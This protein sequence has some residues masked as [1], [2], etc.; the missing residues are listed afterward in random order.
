[1]P[2][3]QNELEKK[4][5][6][7]RALLLEDAAR[8]RELERKAALAARQKEEDSRK[9]EA[10]LRLQLWQA[11]IKALEETKR[12]E[13]E[14][15]KRK[16]EEAEVARQVAEE[17][18]EREKVEERKARTAA[19][20]KSHEER[21]FLFSHILEVLPDLRI[22]EAVALGSAL[23]KAKWEESQI[24]KF[25]ELIRDKKLFSSS[26]IQD[27][28]QQI[29]QKKTVAQIFPF[30][31]MEEIL[32]GILELMDAD[33]IYE[34]TKNMSQ[35]IINLGIPDPEVRLKFQDVYINAATIYL[36]LARRIKRR[37]MIDEAFQVYYKFI[38]SLGEPDVF[39][40]DPASLY[41]TERWDTLLQIQ[42]GRLA[43]LLKT[44]QTDLKKATG[45]FYVLLALEY[46]KTQIESGKLT[47]EVSQ[48]L[49]EE[50]R[51]MDSVRKYTTDY[52]DI[53]LVYDIAGSAYGFLHL[54][55]PI[56][57]ERE[58]KKSQSIK[59][60]E[61]LV[62]SLEDYINL[63]DQGR[64]SKDH[65][66]NQELFN[67]IIQKIEDHLPKF[68]AEF[69]KLKV[70]LTQDERNLFRFVEG[71]QGLKLLPK[72]LAL[73]ISFL[74]E[75]KNQA[76]QI[77]FDKSAK[78]KV[79]GEGGK[80]PALQ[81]YYD[82]LGLNWF[83]Q[84]FS[85]S[86]IESGLWVGGMTVL[87]QMILE[88][89]FGIPLEI[90]P[91]LFLI[92]GFFQFTWHRLHGRT[93]AF[94]T[95]KLLITALTALFLIP[96]SL[97]HLT[98]SSL[99]VTLPFLL[100]LPHLIVN[101][102]YWH[103][104]VH[105]LPKALLN[106]SFFQ[107]GLWDDFYYGFQIKLLMLKADGGVL[108]GG[109]IEFQQYINSLVDQYKSSQKI[110][111]IQ[112]FDRLERQVLKDL[113]HTQDLNI[114]DPHEIPSL[115]GETVAV[116]VN[117]LYYSRAFNP[118]PLGAQQFSKL[119]LKLFLKQGV[120]V[121]DIPQLLLG[122]DD[123]ETV[124]LNPDASRSR[125]I[126]WLS[127]TMVLE[128][129]KALEEALAMDNKKLETPLIPM[130]NLSAK[131]GE[132]KL[133]FHKAEFLQPRKAF[134][135]RAQA[136]AFVLF[137]MFKE[138][139]DKIRKLVTA[140]T[141]NHGL[142][143]AYAVHLLKLLYPNETKNLFAEIYTS[144]SIK[145]VKMDAIQSQPYTRVVTQDDQGKEFSG[146]DQANAFVKLLEEKDKS[147]GQERTLLHI[148]NG[149]EF[150]VAGYATTGLEIF[151]QLER[152][153]LIHKNIAVTVPM[154]SSGHAAGIAWVLKTLALMRGA[155]IKVIGIQ[156]EKVNAAHQ[157]LRAGKVIEVPVESEHHLDEDQIAVT[158][159]EEFAVQVLLKTLDASVI[160][161][162]EDLIR[163]TM[164]VYDDFSNS[165]QAELRGSRVEVAAGMNALAIES[166][167][168][169]FNDR[170]VII[171]IATGG[172]VS[173][174]LWQKIEA[175]APPSIGKIFSKIAVKMK[176]TLSVLL[177]M[178]LI[179]AIFSN[180]ILFQSFSHSQAQT[181]KEQ[182]LQKHQ[183]LK[184][185]IGSSL[186]VKVTIKPSLTPLSFEK[187]DGEE[188]TFSMNPSIAVAF[189]KE[190]SPILT[191]A[192]EK[193]VKINQALLGQ[194]DSALQAISN[195]WSSPFTANQEASQLLY[196]SVRNIVAP[197]QSDQKN[198]TENQ[199]KLLSNILGDRVY[200]QNNNIQEE[201]QR[202]V[203]NAGDCSSSIEEV[204]SF[205]EEMKEESMGEEENKGS[206]KYEVV[207]V[208][209]NLL[210]TRGEIEKIL[211][212]QGISLYEIKEQFRILTQPR[213]KGKF[214]LK[215]LIRSHGLADGYSLRVLNK[216]GL[217]SLEGL[218]GKIWQEAFKENRIVFIENSLFG[219]KVVGYSQ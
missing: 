207:I 174:E 180:S 125:E 169:L 208:T 56:V 69:N 181:Y 27:L 157:S 131:A 75:D 6:E 175:R 25:L 110:D 163:A 15:K 129:K 144:P 12:V 18:K 195:V 68:L 80:W 184:Q 140:S 50:F 151:D 53:D 32:K 193:R 148:P 84:A 164:M 194:S 179:P 178:F 167:P 160:V 34:K 47:L 161:K 102:Y 150:V 176:I 36:S 42:R 46:L 189:G 43:E 51:R 29:K 165:L 187:L 115:V 1:M 171:G 118:T 155:N 114:D 3:T 132:G 98:G 77:K 138:G 93:D 31:H 130:A 76:G 79:E 218:M 49:F 185:S 70:E 126:E 26:Q 63:A 142:N 30:D 188:A 213:E 24:K 202:L 206:R 92:L 22:R 135:I 196:N 128:S 199:L 28:I 170:E 123:P 10:Q 90:G 141:G 183:D 86:L 136:K 58:K 48:D 20:L 78:E 61:P 153:G 41:S 99:L 72:I 209:D 100:V 9:R 81:K 186:K 143:T 152:M 109:R 127:M 192:V 200:L 16:K 19:A 139:R 145:S 190:D 216:N 60:A 39:A 45:E 4:L 111:L 14:I 95:D 212:N 62:K 67:E 133:V 54:W 112:F 97:F 91:P 147:T 121:I 198:S 159:P 104:K 101:S 162:N 203:L 40:L 214:N 66:K 120:T 197:E 172:N 158:K 211:L 82:R 52:E 11:Q 38:S 122:N 149:D 64:W 204:R 85:P 119:F 205:L 73:R 87:T 182:S 201:N 217:W 154:G 116:F 37:F 83:G 124:W 173:D 215:Q 146:Y 74:S 106:F 168:E 117:A 191:H 65:N 108:K 35:E 57:L 156:T 219:M 7:N 166:F 44:P 107:N 137:K 59:H 23:Y 94:K 8:V 2:D 13:E 71:E 21:K 134:K 89:I 103:R 177:S 5:A 88:R 17:A 105:R 210:K 96:Y 33:T 55:L 113:Q